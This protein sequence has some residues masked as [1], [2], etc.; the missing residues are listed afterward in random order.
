MLV[1]M[2]VLSR[3]REA[4]ERS[5]RLLSIRLA[6]NYRRKTADGRIAGVSAM[7]QSGRQREQWI[8]LAETPGEKDFKETV[9]GRVRQTG[10]LF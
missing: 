9:E 10:S 4:G 8:V 2:Y 1:W 5:L 6:V 7:R 3:R